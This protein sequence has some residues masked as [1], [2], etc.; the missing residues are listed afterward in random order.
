[1][2]ESEKPDLIFMDCQ[3][4]VM[5]GYEATKK[6]REMGID[7][8]IVAVTANAL[9]GEKEKCIAC[10]MTDFL[11]KPFKNRDIQ[12]ILNRWLDMEELEEAEEFS[13][14]LAEL[15]PAELEPLETGN[16]GKSASTDETRDVF[17]LEQALDTFMGDLDLLVSLLKPFVTQM[18]EYL[19]RLDNPAVFC[20]MEEV[21]GIGHAIKGSSRNLSMEELGAAAEEL[22]F[23][24]RDNRPENAGI[25]YEKIKKAFDRV[26]QTLQPYLEK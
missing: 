3:M 21:R 8:P 19:S 23:S 7:T 12:P 20:Q 9:K 15:E 24:G 10:G 14:E 26:K 1:M 13:G 2:A 5:N 6:I 16:A 17:D 25:A 18:E 4:P 22:E 11:P